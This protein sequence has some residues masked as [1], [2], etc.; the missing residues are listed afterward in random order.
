ML[1]QLE[2]ANLLPGELSNSIRLQILTNKVIPLSIKKNK[3]L[4]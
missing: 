1:I 3:K 4:N 2:P